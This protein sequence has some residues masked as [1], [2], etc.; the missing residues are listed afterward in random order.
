MS[1]PSEVL[2]LLVVTRATGE[3][4][5]RA[6]PLREGR[7]VV[8]RTEG[9][10]IR[11]HEVTVARRH[12]ALTVTPERV[13]VEDLSSPCGIYIN[14]ERANDTDLEVGARIQ[15]GGIVCVLRRAGEAV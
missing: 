8:G 5:G 13:H 6:F 7:Y 15:I 3:Y 4:L 2:Y 14:D 10:D 12:V 9:A 1:E 11:I